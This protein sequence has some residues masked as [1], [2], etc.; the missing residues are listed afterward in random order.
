MTLQNVAIGGNW[1]DLSEL[2]FN[3]TCESTT[4][5]IKMLQNWDIYY[6]TILTDIEKRNERINISQFF[7]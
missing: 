2:F 7:L 1:V 4:I 6:Q 5:S 3:T